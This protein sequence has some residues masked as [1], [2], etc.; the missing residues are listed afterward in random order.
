MLLFPEGTSQVEGPP[1]PFRIG[2]LEVAFDCGRPV[3]PVALWY[4]ELVGLAPETD[5]LLGTA[6]MLRHPTQV[7]VRFSP[8][9]W[10]KDFK[11]A[12]LFAEAVEGSVRRA[13]GEIA[14]CRS[15][16]AMAP[17]SPASSPATPAAGGRAAGFLKTD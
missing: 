17:E 2:A 4:S 13:Y 3:Q 10:P 15:A 14:V 7:V 8:L 11:T 6:E 9:L 5:A 16:A 12:A 1:K